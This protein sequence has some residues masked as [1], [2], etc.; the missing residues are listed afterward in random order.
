VTEGVFSA[1]PQ[2][3][4]NPDVLD[5]DLEGGAMEYMRPAPVSSWLR[6]EDEGE[7]RA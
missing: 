1:K 4:R 5:D 7:K 3:A 2:D 6:R